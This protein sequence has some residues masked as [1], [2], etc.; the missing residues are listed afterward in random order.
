MKQH[1]IAFVDADLRDVDPIE[2][3]FANDL[4]LIGLR[5]ERDAAGLTL[6]LRWRSF[7]G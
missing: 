7:G 2:V 1:S 5:L 4:Q 6:K 3:N